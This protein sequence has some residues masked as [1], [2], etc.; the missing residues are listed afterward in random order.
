MSYIVVS[1]WLIGSLSKRKLWNAKYNATA[2]YLTP[3]LPGSASGNTGGVFSANA[4][5]KPNNGPKGVIFI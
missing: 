4:C 2:F 1:F 3:D 5:P